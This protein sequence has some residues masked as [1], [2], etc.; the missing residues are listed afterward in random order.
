MTSSSTIQYLQQE[1]IN[2]KL[3]DDCIRKADNGLIYARSFYLE[4]MC[5]HWDALVWN[6]YQV[7]MPLPWRRK[8][9]IQYLYQP[10]LT[11]QLGIIG[12][13]ITK[14]LTQEFLISVP[15]KFRFW[16]INLN[17]DN[18][19]DLPQFPLKRKHNYFLSLEQSYQRI[20]Q[21]YNQ[22]LKR[23]IKKAKNRNCVYSEEVPLKEVLGPA[24]K[25]FSR[26]TRFSKKEA[27]RFQL[28]VEGLL[29]EDKARLAGV[30][31]NK[32]LCAACVFLFD[33]RTAYYILAT[34]TAQGK[35]TG[36]SHFLL[37]QF[38]KGQAGKIQVLDF[39][40]SDVASVA[41]FYESFGAQSYS[42]GTLRT[43]NLPPW[44]K[45]IKG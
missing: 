28:V 11:P 42:Y 3:W 32:V 35:T 4:T 5:D 8:A 45:W 29:K 6:N 34:T 40:G 9:G 2:K 15:G 36:A 18:F 16:E 27:N 38:I 43:N 25:Q 14:E 22:N 39:A 31:Q 13:G 20:E 19:F 17:K 10:F 44:I 24:L 37:D 33:H 23:N 26:Y 12:C 21:G 41:F 7:V 1:E 30:Y